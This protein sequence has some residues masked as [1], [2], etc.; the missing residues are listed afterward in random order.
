MR[1]Y[2]R[3]T[4]DEPAPP[5]PP[6][7][8]QFTDRDQEI[9]LAISRFEGFLSVPQVQDL[10]FP[11]TTAGNRRT[12]KRL[13]MLW[14]ARYLNRLSRRQ[15]YES[16]EM[17][18]WLAPK[19]A[20][21]VAS[22]WGTTLKDFKWVK[23]PRLIQVRHDLMIN[24]FHVDV[25]LQS[26]ETDV[27]IVDWQS[28]YLFKRNAD[29]V[30]YTDHRNKRVKKNY[31]PDSYFMLE[32]KVEQGRERLR[33]LLEIDR[34]REGKEQV[35]RVFN[36]K[37]LLG[38]PYIESEA[39][40]SRFGNKSGRMLI[41]TSGGKRLENLITKTAERFDKLAQWYMFTIFDDV[42]KETVLT[43]PI[44]WQYKDGNYRQV[45]LLT[46]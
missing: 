24:E 5:K 43:E 34:G 1:D 29:K 21:F 13:E 40:L 6:D 11:P 3:P 30:E 4:E 39:Y 17:I 25:E 46:G 8:W 33:F 23:K 18:Y 41:V 22:E 44:W 26:R 42:N 35:H 31:E 37:I 7:R 9:V 14:R 20:K 16:P 19:G 2:I 28:S 32:Q 38:V 12:K 15:R 10:F 36:E 45:S 27:E